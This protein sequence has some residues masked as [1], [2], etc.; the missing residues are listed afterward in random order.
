MSI[1]YLTRANGRT[2]YRGAFGKVSSVRGRSFP[3]EDVI[4][5]DD[6]KRAI[7]AHLHAMRECELA[8][9]VDCLRKHGLLAQGLSLLELGA[10]TGAQARD[11]ESLGFRVSAIDMVESNYSGDR[12]RP[13]ADYDG[14]NIPF[15]DRHFDIVFSS[16]VLE[17]VPHIGEFQREIC[18]VLKNDGAAVHVLPSTAWRFWTN[19]SYYPHAVSLLWNIRGAKAA[20][21]RRQSSGVRAAPW[22]T[23]ARALLPPR[24]GEEGNWFTELWYFSQSYWSRFFRASGWDITSAEGCRLFYTGYSILASSLPISARR[25]L[26][27]VLGSATNVFVLRKSTSRTSE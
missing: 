3:Y 24:H 27:I 11:L 20:M 1:L 4:V 21:A 2:E 16:N 18:R 6:H 22:K 15:P 13:V 10:G 25:M 12:V 9:V 17:H 26:A 5:V 8:V 19:V 14:R 23:L 7:L